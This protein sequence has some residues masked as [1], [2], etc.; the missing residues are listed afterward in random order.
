MFY[1]LLLITT[2]G[3][4]SDPDGASPQEAQQTAHAVLAAYEAF[5]SHCSQQ[6]C[7]Q[8]TRKRLISTRD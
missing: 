6:L 4:P 5:C 7:V 2:H 3:Y 1:S 8:R